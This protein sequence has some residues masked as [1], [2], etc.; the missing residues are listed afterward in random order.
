MDYKI[1][2]RT[3]TKSVEINSA[4]IESSPEYLAGIQGNDKG[5]VRVRMLAKERNRFI[6]SLDNRVYSIILQGR[7]LNSLSFLANGRHFLSSVGSIRSDSTGSLV[8]SANEL[9]T[10]NFPAKVVK[11]TSKVGQ[12]LQEGETLIVLEAMKMEAQIKAPRDCLVE[13]IFVKEGDMVGKGKP[14]IRLRFG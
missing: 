6:L 7:S 4:E 10:S 5:E 13:E 3:D 1:T 11:I 12:R 8:A 9:V 14:M 2:I